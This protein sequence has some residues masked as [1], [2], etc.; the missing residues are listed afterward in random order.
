MTRR[1]FGEACGSDHQQEAGSLVGRF[2]TDREAVRGLLPVQCRV[3]NNID[4]YLDT[5]NYSDRRKMEY[6]CRV[7]TSVVAL[8]DVSA[9]RVMKRGSLMA[10]TS[11]LRPMTSAG[12]TAWCQRR[13]VTRP[14]PNFLLHVQVWGRLLVPVHGDCCFRTFALEFAKSSSSGSTDMTMISQALGGPWIRPVAPVCTCKWHPE[15]F[16]D[17]GHHWLLG[18]VRLFQPSLHF[19]C[20]SFFFFACP[21]LENILPCLRACVF[22]S[23]VCCIIAKSTMKISPSARRGERGPALA[24]MP[25]SCLLLFIALAVYSCL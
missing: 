1:R 25:L 13:N 23:T 6:A 21:A 22:A 9:Q 8:V 18:P 4:A 10:A 3:T 24:L 5:E 20:A 2:E 11:S 16:I 14:I 7:F 19:G 17:G 12:R 15:S